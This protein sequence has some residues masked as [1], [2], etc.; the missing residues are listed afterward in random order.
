MKGSDLEGSADHWNSSH[1]IDAIQLMLSV[2]Y[3]A[4]ILQGMSD[5]WG[6]GMNGD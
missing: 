5:E 1:F 6:M 3:M 4:L 2:S